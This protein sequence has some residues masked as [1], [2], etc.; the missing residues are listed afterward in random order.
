MNPPALASGPTGL[1]ATGDWILTTADVARVVVE[2]AS[3]TNVSTLDVSGITRV[4]GAGAVHLVALLDRLGAGAVLHGDGTARTLIELYRHRRPAVPQPARTA[5]FVEALGASTV[6]VADAVVG[7]MEATGAAT[8]AVAASLARPRGTAWRDVPMLVLRTGAN[9]MG[10]VALTNLLIGGIVGFMGVTLLQAYGAA[11]LVPQMV[12]LAHMREL[13]PVMTAIIVAGRSGA[14]FAAE[15][16]TMKVSEEIDALRTTG[17]DPWRW[18]VVPRLVALLIALPLLTAWG[19][20]VGLLGGMLASLPLLP[21]LSFA[22][23]LDISLRS[24]TVANAAMGLGKPFLFAI[25]IAVLACIQGLNARGG[26][27]AVGVRTTNAVV[28]AVVAV[29]AID[30]VVALLGTLVG[31]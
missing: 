4:D 28:Q 8:S 27:S 20:A 11:S 9:G 23:Y 12:M 15:L 18:L 5:G 24:F 2:N 29:I 16:G 19:I 30:C 26:A 7:A 31:F 10:V 13:G 25:A 3:L 17:L 6:G 22:A 1:G 14:G 21:Q